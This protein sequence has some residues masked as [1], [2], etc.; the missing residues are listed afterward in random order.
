MTN[1]PSDI[2]F[3]IALKAAANATDPNERLHHLETALRLKPDQELAEAA[4]VA[5]MSLELSSIYVAVEK[6]RVIGNATRQVVGNIYIEEPDGRLKP[7]T[8]D[9]LA[10]LEERHPGFAKNW[11]LEQE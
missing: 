3:D 5:A 6:A 2:L 7:L 9:D 4:I 1:E 10:D 8:G 11:R